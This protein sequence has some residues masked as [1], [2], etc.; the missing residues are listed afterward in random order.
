MIKWDFIFMNNVN[1]IFL[2]CV[3]YSS[4]KAFY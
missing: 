3:N 4:L 2:F 1:C